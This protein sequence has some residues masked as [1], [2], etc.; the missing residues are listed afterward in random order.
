MRSDESG[1]LLDNESIQMANAAGAHDHSNGAQRLPCDRDRQLRQ[2]EQVVKS[3]GESRPVR[4]V[5]SCAGGC[6]WRGREERDSRV[7]E[8]SAGPQRAAVPCEAHS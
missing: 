7:A 1:V 3:A 4:S 2:I 5:K 6:V 8:I